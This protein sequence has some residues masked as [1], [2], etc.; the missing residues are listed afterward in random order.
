MAK[1][2]GGKVKPEEKEETKRTAGPLKISLQMRLFI[3]ILSL[4]IA[5]ISTV[6]ITSY[7]KATDTAL[8]MM[9]DRM[10][11]EVEM[12]Y[13]IAQNLAYIHAGD[14]DT[15]IKKYDRY[16]KNLRS[17]LAQDGLDSHT[18]LI[19]NNEAISFEKG[20]G[21]L[22]IPPNLINQVTKE[23]TN[24]F[25][26][27]IDGESYTLGHK[28]IQELDGIFLLAIPTDEYM[29]GVKQMAKIML[30]TVM[31][32]IGI[33]SAMI[34]LLVRTLTNP[35]I[36]LRNVM[37]E[38]RE[39]NLSKELDIKTSVPEITSLIKS[40]NLMM[41]Q[42]RMM[43]SE[44]NGT[45]REL[46]V[47]GTD[48]SE[49]TENV[50]Y[51]NKQLIEAIHV[52]KQGAEQTA[53]SS[54]ANINTFE[55][56]KVHLQSV[57]E[58]MDNVFSNAADMNNSAVKGEKSVSHIIS[59]LNNFEGEFSS[60]AATIKGVKEHSLSIAN[61]VSII[62]TIAEQTK[63]L[64]LNAA[65]EAA[66]AGEAGKGFAVVANEVRKLAEQSSG[67][68]EN[69]TA[70]IQLMEDISARA[71]SEFERIYQNMHSQLAGA[72]ESRKSFDLLMGEI[73]KL[74]FNLTT[75]KEEIQVLN[76]SLPLME[77]SS[78]SFVSI[79]QET[80]ASAEEML[81]A[82][83]QQSEKMDEAHKVGARL[84]GLSKSLSSITGQF[85]GV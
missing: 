85:K 53:S 48:L 38:V 45:T 23:K 84:V 81:T 55:N 20:G 74:N 25:Y 37:R 82:S 61:V 67:A 76:E 4:L 19:K 78:L 9:E 2:A 72:G 1:D 71:S 50:L 52:V 64:A 57:L 32:S 34:I 41:E 17:D 46:S 6:G 70:S 3:L 56:M 7:E 60:M 73:D 39:G 63:L 51:H 21:K 77:Q 80:L 35:L 24:V 36:K 10:E 44:I 49:S 28:P 11:R 33:S 79:S 43:I 14:K 42:M 68:T 15:F 27:K 66:R 69:I 22:K 83:E 54:E 40:F 58:K 47:T 65:I 12:L 5:S 75:I 59:I 13:A 31:V 18:F 29:G 62:Q 16:I 8:N 26:Y 30:W